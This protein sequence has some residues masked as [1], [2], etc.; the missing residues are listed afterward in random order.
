MTAHYVAA[1]DPILRDDSVRSLVDELL[2]DD[3]R[4]FALEE[5]V[6]G[7]DGGEAESEDEADEV[8]TGTPFAAAL[9]AARTPPMMTAK[10]VVVVRDVGN[11]VAAEVAV[12]EVYLAD[13]METTELVLVAGGAGRN[14]SKT[15]T[16]IAK[17]VGTHG[18][19]MAQTSE[20]PGDVLARFL[21][22]AGIT[23]QPDAA[24]VVVAHVG[25][26]VGLL[27]GLVEIIA[28]AF[29]VGAE[30]TV[31]DVAPYLGDEGAIPMWD[32][33]NAIEKGDTAT[34][35]V[36]LQRLLTVTSP[37]QPDAVHPLQVMGFLHG[38]YRRLLRLDDPDITTQEDAAAALGG[39][40]SPRAAG[41]RLRQARSLGTDGLRQAFDA[42]VKADLDLK[43]ER[44]IPEDAAMSILVA[45][46]TALTKRTAARR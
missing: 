38:H 29:P 30:L 17:L 34:A 12:L 7:A 20:K 46:L 16:A 36:V 26:D 2:G 13:P 6:A 45:R 33:T 5:Y 41:F 1:G 10:R 27:P 32:L 8:P 21:G 31:A 15:L 18:E 14:A 22:E 23:L 35:L 44:A 39:R 9:N 28:G 24:K 4:S 42:L 3:D 11:L 40:M 25:G 37:S 19:V 43:G